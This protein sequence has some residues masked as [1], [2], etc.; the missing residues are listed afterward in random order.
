MTERSTEWLKQ[1][2]LVPRSDFAALLG[3]SEKALSNRPRS[4]LPADVV[5]I[6]RATFYT[7]DSVRAFLERHTTRQDA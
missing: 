4:Q 2:G 6:G 1:F 7:V 3:V 5:R